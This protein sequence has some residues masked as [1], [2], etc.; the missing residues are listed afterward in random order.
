MDVAVAS[1]QVR[2]LDQ[3]VFAHG[4]LLFAAHA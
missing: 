1:M 4:A 2:D 3:A